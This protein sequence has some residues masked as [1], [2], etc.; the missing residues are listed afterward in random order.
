M[1][2]VVASTHIHKPFSKPSHSVSQSSM[3]RSSLSLEE[4]VSEDYKSFKIIEMLQQ[5]KFISGLD[6]LNNLQNFQ[7]STDANEAQAELINNLNHDVN[8]FAD[9]G[10]DS[11]KGS[12]PT[13]EF[14]LLK[15]KLPKYD[16]SKDY[17]IEYWKT[18]MDI[19][20]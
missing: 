5:D 18:F 9:N 13:D 19:K 17:Y 20:V 12:I 4:E 3:D 14:E 10:D 8:L 2:S 7:K 16:S 15:D 11:E 6:S 1:S